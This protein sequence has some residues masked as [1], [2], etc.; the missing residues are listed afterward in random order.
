MSAWKLRRQKNF[1][2]M[3]KSLFKKKNWQKG[4]PSVQIETSSKNRDFLHKKLE[5][6]DFKVVSFWFRCYKSRDWPK[7]KKLLILILFQ[8]LKFYLLTNY[9]FF[10]ILIKILRKSIIV[11]DLKINKE[12]STWDQCFSPLYYNYV[13]QKSGEK[14]L[15]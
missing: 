15:K 12:V 13:R 2:H 10:Y 11:M 6:E 9:F 1:Y 5:V 4:L 8:I 3:H 14:H 7:K